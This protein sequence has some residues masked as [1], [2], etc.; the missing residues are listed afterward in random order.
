[1]LLSFILVHAYSGALILFGTIEKCAESAI[2][3]TSDF[4]LLLIHKTNSGLEDSKNMLY[5][6]G[7]LY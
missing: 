2:L 7:Q 3:P 1:M 4:E 5:C 6:G